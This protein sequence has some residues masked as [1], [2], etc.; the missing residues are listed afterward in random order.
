[1]AWLPWAQCDLSESHCGEQLK[2]RS[3]AARL[4]QASPA[5]LEVTHRPPRPS[6]KDGAGD[7][8][9]HKGRWRRFPLHYNVIVGTTIAVVGL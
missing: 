4:R 2:L 8:S 9:A 6:I 1:M 3:L 5:H 7:L